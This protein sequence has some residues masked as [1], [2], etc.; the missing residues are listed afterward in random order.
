MSDPLSIAVSGLNNA[1]QQ[2]VNATASIVNASSTRDAAAEKSGAGDSVIASGLVTIAE[3]RNDYGANAAVVKAVKSTH[4]A[5]NKAFD[6]K[7]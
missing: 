2:V 1:A 6:I 5:L 3:A 4:D 7:V